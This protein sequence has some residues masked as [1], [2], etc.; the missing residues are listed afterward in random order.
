[1]SSTRDRRTTREKTLGGPVLGLLVAFSMLGCRAPDSR[2]AEEQSH[3]ASAMGEMSA[4]TIVRPNPNVPNL[5]FTN[6]DGDVRTLAGLRG[7]PVLLSF[8]YT[9]CP[10]ASMCPLSTQNVAKAQELLTPEE[11][12]RIAVVTVTFDPDHDTPSVLKEYGQ[13]YG[14]KFKDWQ[15]WAGSHQDTADLMDVYGVWAMKEGDEFNHNMRNVILAPDGSFATELRGSAWDPA[16][17][18]SRLQSLLGES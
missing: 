10:M 11:R 6:Q 16:Q 7:K 15:F 3:E 12:E 8:I 18:A 9:R 13:A 17:A 4:P 2:Q 1:M 14:A 5:E